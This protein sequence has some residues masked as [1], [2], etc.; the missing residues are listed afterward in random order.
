MIERFDAGESMSRRRLLGLAAQ[1]SLALPFARMGTDLLASRAPVRSPGTLGATVSFRQARWLGLDPRELFEAVLSAGFSPV[2]VIAYWSEVEATKGKFELSETMWQL[3]RARAANVKVV[4]SFGAKT[5][6]YPE[7]NVP[8]W[9]L[10]GL[11][12]RGSSDRE[13]FLL[14]HTLAFNAV[15][16]AAAGNDSALA[17]VQPGNEDLEPSEVTQW[18]SLS[19]SFVRSVVADARARTRLPILLTSSMPLTLADFLFRAFRGHIDDALTYVEVADAVAFNTHV[20][21]RNSLVGLTSNFNPGPHYWPML[22]W[23][24]NRTWAAGKQAIIGELQAEPFDYTVEQG[25]TWGRDPNITTRDVARLDC[26]VRDM[27]FG[28]RLAWGVEFAYWRLKQGDG[29]YWSQLVNAAGPGGEL[30]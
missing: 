7:F 2:R 15:V 1:A 30:L 8:G 26:R 11:G 29:S 14:Q 24:R 21:I 18:R 9:V 17:Y 23:L 5:P 6:R 16:L 22:A 27:Q 19:Q 20:K 12:E 10:Q 13:Q 3:D 28:T 4:L 25:D